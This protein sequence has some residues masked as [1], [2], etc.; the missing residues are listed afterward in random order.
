[1]WGTFK[2][3]QL[4]LFYN[5][6]LS[7][8]VSSGRDRTKDRGDLEVSSSSLRV[9]PKKRSAKGVQPVDGGESPLAGLAGRSFWT[10]PMGR[11]LQAECHPLGRDCRQ[12]MECA[13]ISTYEERPGLRSK[14]GPVG[15]TELVW[16]QEG[17]TQQCLLQTV[18]ASCLQALS[19]PA[20]ICPKLG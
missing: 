6:D 13:S 9:D 15:E 2:S 12:H 16:G 3:Q 4:F 11:G 18:L 14:E 7:A 10:I 19:S 1:M 17:G 20:R 8:T 5:N